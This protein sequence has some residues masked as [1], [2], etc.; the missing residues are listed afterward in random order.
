MFFCVSWAASLDLTSNFALATT[1]TGYYIT[2]INNY[3]TD[4]E[5]QDNLLKLIEHHKTTDLFNILNQ[6]ITNTNDNE[7]FNNFLKLCDNNNNILKYII[8]TFFDGLA[9]YPFRYENITKNKEVFVNPTEEYNSDKKEKIKNKFIKLIDNLKPAPR[10]PPVIVPNSKRDRDR[11]PVADP[12]TPKTQRIGE[13]RPMEYDGGGDKK[14]KIKN[15]K[16]RKYKNIKNKKTKKYKNI[17]KK[18]LENIKKK[19]TKKYKNIKKKKTRKK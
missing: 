10:P 1:L 6:L 4:C 15:K 12:S 13:S 9:E 2:G 19:K 11:S 8:T 5:I 14:L 18:K 7:I 17:K 16:T 3:E